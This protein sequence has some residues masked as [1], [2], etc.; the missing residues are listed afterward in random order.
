MTYLFSYGTLQQANV[1]LS[2]FGRQLEG[3]SDLLVGFILA[4]QRIS[5]PNVIA[6]SGSALHP[7]L[8]Q[9]GSRQHRVPGTAFA[10]TSEELNLADSYE[11]DAYQ[12][13]QVLL[14]SGKT[15]WVYVEAQP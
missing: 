9:T 12:R 10:I 1:Q 11:T 5:D 2:T 13:I 14:A 8:R 7:I 4:Q 15:A 3:T 6:I